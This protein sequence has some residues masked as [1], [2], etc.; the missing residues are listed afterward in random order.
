MGFNRM[1]AEEQPEMGR[2]KPTRQIATAVS[3]LKNNFSYRNMVSVFREEITEAR[4]PGRSV[5]MQAAI[6]F[7]EA[8]RE[9]RSPWYY[10]YTG[11][12]LIAIQAWIVSFVV[13]LSI[14]VCVTGGLMEAM[15]YVLI[16]IALESIAVIAMPVVVLVELN[17][18]WIPDKIYEV[19]V[20]PLLISGLAAFLINRFSVFVVL[21][22]QRF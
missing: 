10:W 21:H 9:S 5:L 6:F 4:E 8:I 14:A 1:E 15:I 20:V 13:M 7:G 22:S 18:N 12:R 11:S 16:G 2:E 17:Y 3:Q 19:L